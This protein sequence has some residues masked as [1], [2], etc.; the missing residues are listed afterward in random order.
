MAFEIARLQSIPEMY[1]AGEVALH[2]EMPGIRR[3]RATARRRRNRELEANMVS[4]SRQNA[5]ESYL[6]Q[7]LVE[8]D[9]EYGKGCDR[10]RSPSNS[11]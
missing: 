3:E 7:G 9:K 4:A 6:F 10:L 11:P 1:T 8:L 5:D 2:N